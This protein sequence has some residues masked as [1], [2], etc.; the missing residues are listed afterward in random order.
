M[1]SIIC[2]KEGLNCFLEASGLERVGPTR[3]YTLWIQDGNGRLRQLGNF[4]ADT[5]GEA[6]FY[7]YAD[8]DLK[9]ARNLLVTVEPWE[10][11]TNQP[12]GPVIFVSQP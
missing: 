12:Q 3:V 8:R 6:S 9:N 7:T 4:D 1:G 5:S 2:L 10:I 11:G